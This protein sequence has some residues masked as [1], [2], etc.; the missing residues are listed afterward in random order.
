MAKAIAGDE[1]LFLMSD[2]RSLAQMRMQFLLFGMHWLW[3][4]LFPLPVATQGPPCCAGV[5]TLKSLELSFF[6]SFFLSLSLVA[7]ETL[8]LC[9]KAVLLTD[10]L[11]CFLTKNC[12]CLWRRATDS[13]FVVPR[14]DSSLGDSEGGGYHKRP[15]LHHQ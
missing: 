2:S 7:P 9:E 12:M 15:D 8:G 6:L 1:V 5:R 3:W 11:M 4:H 10:L 13:T 14:C